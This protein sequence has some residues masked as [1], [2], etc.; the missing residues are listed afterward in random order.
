MRKLLPILLVLVAGGVAAQGI[1]WGVVTSGIATNLRGLS[2]ARR[3]NSTDGV[4][5][6]ASGSKGVILQSD[7]YAEPY[8]KRLHV[9]DGDDL[10]FRGIRAID[11]KTAYV[12]SSG[13]GDKSRIY[14]TVDGGETWEMQYTDKRPSFFLDDIVCFTEKQ[15]FALG[16]P[17]DGKFL[18]LSTEDGKHWHELPRDTMPAI[19]PGEGAFAASGSSLAIF[20][21]TDIYFG[22]GGGATAR[23][24]H[25]PDLGK[26]WI[27]ADTP[28]AAGNASSGVFSLV[29]VRNNV[30][31]VGGDYRVTDGS[32]RVAAYSSDG[33]ATWHLASSQPGG[34]RSA[35]TC[36]IEELAPRA[37]VT[38]G[39][40]GED[41]S[42]DFGIT[43][44]HTDSQN[45]N[46]VVAFGDEAWAVGARGT[47]AT[48]RGCL[49]DCLTEKIKIP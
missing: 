9:G 17:I 26:T 35:V 18:I 37:C 10:D 29:R 1:S 14:K 25:S 43:W 20:G 7:A 33:G 22:T 46:A 40:N 34:Y 42:V 8:W 11:E 28:L 4:V 44:K 47:I 23:V 12:I 27:V 41:L 39:P 5:V 48:L 6:W 32:A 21:K 3:S 49:G 16:D 2:A 31:A 45:L 38:V 24:F 36:V 30:I 13:E 15:C 19:I